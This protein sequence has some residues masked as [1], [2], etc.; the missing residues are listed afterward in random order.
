M[1]E[2]LKSVFIMLLT[3]SLVGLLGLSFSLGIY[4]GQQGPVERLAGLIFPARAGAAKDE[5]VFL[6][7][8]AAWPGQAAICREDGIYAAITAQEYDALC[9]PS[10]PVFL[11]YQEALGSSGEPV[12]VAESDFMALLGGPAIYLRW[13]SPLPLWMHYGW[14]ESDGEKPELP[15]E[16]VAVGTVDGQSVVLAFAT[17]DGRYFSMTTGT[18][19]QALLAACEVAE[20]PNSALAGASARYGGL[21]PY[22]L[23]YGDGNSALGGFVRL[24]EYR[25]SLRDY[26]GGLP[27]QMLEAFSLRYYL[28]ESMMSAGGAL[29]YMDGPSE[30]TASADGSLRLLRSAREEPITQGLAPGSHAETI[31]V[32]EYARSLV[33]AVWQAAEASGQ[34]S[35][36]SV[37][38]SAGT[39]TIRFEWQLGGLYVETP[40][41]PAYVV[42]E[43]GCLAA[44]GVWPMLAVA[45]ETAAIAY[46]QYAAAAAAMGGGAPGIS[47][48][49]HPRE[50]DTSE[51]ERPAAELKP[52]VAVVDA[53]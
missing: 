34:L 9:N 30:L 13:N 15:L 3:L 10:S 52:R 20:S 40:M 32:V 45:D 8:P 47:Y 17:G 27:R 23:I 7:Q 35:L 24:P 46:P 49:W 4:G 14:A 11:V 33:S 5:H 38:Y 41:R 12:A 44:A 19:L 36:E 29:R 28:S 22:A 16:T 1:I 53:P 25:L 18:N 2:R 26:T 39:Y 51:G 21:P 37:D 42:V 50:S 48:I 43:N 31:R 6:P